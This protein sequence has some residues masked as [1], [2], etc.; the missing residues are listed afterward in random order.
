MGWEA[1]LVAAV[2][3]ALVIALAKEVA[4]ADLLCVAALTVLLLAGE[5]DRAWQAAQ[6]PP[7]ADASSIKSKLPGVTEAA[8]GFGNTGLLTVG[9]LFLVVAGLVQT[10]GMSLIAE[11]LIGRP[12]TVF[13]AQLRLLLPVTT[14][15]AVLNNTPLVAM[16]MPVCDDIAK[17][18]RIS[19]S[20]LFMPMA[21]AAT[22]GGVC[23]MIGT[24]TNL[25]VNGLIESQTDFEPF[26]MWD[27]AWAGIPCAIA[28]CAY[29]M[30]F[31]QWLLP[32]R[33]PAL[34]YSDDPRKYTVEMEVEPGGV[35]IDRSIEQAG[36]RHLPGLFLAEIEREGEVLPA[37]GPW[38]RLR[39]GD[40]LVFV[41]VVE[42]V[43]DL[44]KMR[45]LRPATDQLVKLGAPETQRCLMEAVVSNRCPLVGKNI[46][47]GRFRSKYNAA[48]IAVA[49]DGERIPG[50]IGDIVLHA[51]D[52]LLLEAHNDFART[53]RNSSDFYLVSHVENS[54]PMRHGRA[55]L[56]LG[57][58]IAMIAVTS[59]LAVDML[60]AA[61]V[62]GLVMIATRCLTAAEARQSIDW[63]VLV[64]IGAALGLGKA[65]QSSGLAMT[66]ADQLVRWAG[67]NPYV[68]LAVIY[69]LGMLLT[70]LVT[71]NAAA[72]L[73][74]PLAMETSESL[75]V[76]YV[77]FV[78]AIMIAASMGF[79]TP[80]G[81][82]TNLMVY[83]PG[84]YKFSDYLR[85]GI[86]LDLLMMVITVI[87]APLIWPF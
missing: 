73:M 63:P 60:A 46:R 20:K 76:N 33:Q 14:M 81:Y 36:L 30:A 32:D 16:F 74:F 25:V 57:L 49:R 7:G 52:T 29:I 85:L 44:R 28:G 82:Q 69:F 4:G 31:S 59:F 66:V 21:F 55:W 35:L 64:T 86:P 45:G 70:E 71:N 12:K 2:V 41:G 39:A 61:L 10:G 65:L 9:A 27:I 51:G 13:S 11:P 18:C 6:L 53:N 26:K 80:F 40:R 34:S 50:K 19:P 75:G 38:E 5:I 8:A 67:P 24:S 1:W 62:V 68:Q 58:L 84:G 43:V 79:A 3:I 83:G 15:S 17:K 42:S 54:A 72:V 56:A 48:V 22:L 47:D 23:T 78:M 87:L 77:P 37:P